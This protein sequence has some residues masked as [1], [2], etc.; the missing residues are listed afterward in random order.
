MSQHLLYC[1]TGQNLEGILDETKSRIQYLKNRIDKIDQRSSRNIDVEFST[2]TLFLI[3]PTYYRFTQQADLVRLS[4]TLKHVPNLH[5]IIVEDFSSKT[6]LVSNILKETGLKN[7]HLNIGT[8]RDLV[9]GKNDPRW[10][11][12]RG[13]DQRNY[14]LSWIRKHVNK[15]KQAVVY[16]ADDDNTYHLKLFEEVR[17]C[18]SLQILIYRGK[19]GYIKKCLTIYLLPFQ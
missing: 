19:K 16:F 10:K 5:W 3:T 17:R 6:E 9:R 13:V 11:K 1:F 14:G 7:T 8:S 15:N 12:H 18:L 4:H 2:V